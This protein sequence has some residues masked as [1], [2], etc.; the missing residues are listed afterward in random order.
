[1][2]LPAVVRQFSEDLE[3]SQLDSVGPTEAAIYRT[4]EGTAYVD[5]LAKKPPAAIDRNTKDY[6]TLK[7]EQELR[8]QLAQKQGQ[9]K[10]LTKEEQAKVN[11]QLAKEAAI[12]EEVSAVATKMRRGIGI[13]QSL[14]TGPPTEAE[15][16]MGPAS[17]LLIA[18]IRAGAGIVLG[19]LPAV[20]FI[21]CSQKISARL[22]VLKPFIGAATL[23]TIGSLQL[24]EE[25]EQ[26][27][28]GGKSLHV[29]DSAYA[30]SSRPCH[31]SA[32]PSPIHERATPT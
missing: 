32:V 16:W 24:S 30:N 8:A 18:I 1:M 21:K 29:C 10:K 17:D 23:R 31:Q 12:R 20:A 4:P 28:L 13:I 14:A 26:E 2:A 27:N 11:A 6:D 3:P 22:G 9:T 5:V 25:Y 19:D 7:W 15:Q